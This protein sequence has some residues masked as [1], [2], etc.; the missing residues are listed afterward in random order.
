MNNKRNIRLIGKNFIID[1]LVIGKK[2]IAHFLAVS[3]F[4]SSCQQAALPLNLEQRE[5]I[6]AFFEEL[7]LEH[8]GAYT[9][10]G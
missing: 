9:L 10:L 3:I 6:G 1:L 8:G 4:F 5:K 7:M 2:K